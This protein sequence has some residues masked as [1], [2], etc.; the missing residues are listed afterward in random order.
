VNDRRLVWQQAP[1]L[2]ARPDAVR[3][4]TNG[5][6]TGLGPVRGPNAE[7][8]SPL[9]GCPWDRHTTPSRRKFRV[10]RTDMPARQAGDKEHSESEQSG[11]SCVYR[12]FRIFRSSGKSG[13]AVSGS[14]I[15]PSGISFHSSPSRPRSWNGPPP[16]GI[17]LG[18]G[19]GVLVRDISIQITKNL[20]SGVT[21][22]FDWEK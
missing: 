12:I 20:P 16:C 22:G 9:Q 2:T 15:L 3:P 13:R 21:E 10:R 7:P 14:P 8:S 17:G 18:E 11:G 1:A 5:A 4:R 19:P 6:A